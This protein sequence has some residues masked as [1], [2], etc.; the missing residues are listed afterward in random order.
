MK[1]FKLIILLALFLTGL[2]TTAKAEEITLFNAAGEPVAYIDGADADLTIYMWNGTAVAYLV[3]TEDEGFNIY[4]FNGKH[5]GWYEDGII[6]DHEGYAIGFKESKCPVVT[7]Y[8]T[9]KSYK[10][11]KP[12]K[13][14]KEFEPIKPIYRTQISDGSLSLFLMKGKK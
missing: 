12:Y 1:H 13:D 11:Y 10:A 3:A 6:R 2:S 8:E 4:G 9:Y 7:K 14:N 5:L